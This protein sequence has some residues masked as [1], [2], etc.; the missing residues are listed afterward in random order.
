MH[1]HSL[2]TIDG[3]DTFDSGA[4]EAIPRRSTSTS[5]RNDEPTNANP[6]YMC[7]RLIIHVATKLDCWW[8]S[9][10][11]MQGGNRCINLLL[12]GINAEVHKENE[13]T[14]HDTAV[15]IGSA[16]RRRRRDAATTTPMHGNPDSATTT[17]LRNHHN[18]TTDEQ[19]R[20]SKTPVRGM[21]LVS[22]N[23]HDTVWKGHRQLYPE[24]DPNATNDD[25]EHERSDNDDNPST[26]APSALWTWRGH[27]F[28]RIEQRC[29]D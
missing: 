7:T 25:N 5:G 27:R 11:D 12:C 2:Y 13:G 4:C 20:I 28:G 24:S 18:N 23:T 14:S 29:I 8:D 26:V 19:R 6:C 9:A 10:A 21:G 22:C 1:R 16:M 3:R 15:S 17:R